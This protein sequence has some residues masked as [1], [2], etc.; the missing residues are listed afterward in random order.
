MGFDVHSF[1]GDGAL[2]LGGVALDGP[3]LSGH[4]DADAVC[5][6]AADAVLGA[7]GLPDIGTLF[8]SSDERLLGASSIEFLRDVAE[9]IRMDGCWIG[10]VDVVIA[11]ERPVLGPHVETM[12]RNLAEALRAAAEPMGGG[13]GVSVKAKRG[14]GIGAIGRAEGIAVWA[15]A[16]AERG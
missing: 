2:V 13:V 8:P 5:H 7:A 9:R 11:A 3:G 10:N 12:A 1:G 16:L 4:S 6:A 14:E 15:V